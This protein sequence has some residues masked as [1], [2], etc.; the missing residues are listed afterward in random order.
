[1]IDWKWQGLGW[2][3][4]F[5]LESLV[6]VESLDD[7]K[8]GRKN[9]GLGKRHIEFLSDSIEFMDP[10]AHPSKEK[11]WLDLEWGVRGG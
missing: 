11:S 8:W 9:L 10:E 6:M 2:H 5:W 4:G 7:W 3:S 1:M